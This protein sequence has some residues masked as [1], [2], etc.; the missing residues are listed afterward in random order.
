M[1]I[2]RHHDSAN[3]RRQ[4]T[5][6]AGAGRRPLIVADGFCTGCGRFAPIR[7]YLVQARSRGGMLVLDDTQALGIFGRM[8]G[9]EHPYGLGGGGSLRAHNIE[10][11]NVIVVSS[12]AKGFGVP[13]AMV[14]GSSARISAFEVQSGTQVHSSPPSF[15]DLHAA[16]LALMVNRRAGEAIRSRLATLIRRFRRQLHSAGIPLLNT[17]FPLQ[18]LRLRNDG[19]AAELHRRLRRMGIGAVL[20]RPGCQSGAAVS[21]VITASHTPADID[22]AARTTVYALGVHRPILEHGR[23]CG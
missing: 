20:H 23:A 14:A 2:F 4:L 17:L 7:H 19:K 12:M 9:V 22:R 16:E 13:I 1:R 11:P 5:Q 10:D 18:S 3:L 8:P 21:L 15:A 6:D